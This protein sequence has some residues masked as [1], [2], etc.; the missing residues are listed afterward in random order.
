MADIE[1][2]DTI[3][4]PNKTK[5]A[6]WAITEGSQE[7][8]KTLDRILTDDFETHE[9]Q[10][11]LDLDLLL[12]H[13]VKFSNAHAVRRL[14]QFGADHTQKVSTTDLYCTTGFGGYKPAIIN[15]W[16]QDKI[17]IKYAQQHT[18]WTNDMGKQP[19]LKQIADAAKRKITLLLKGATVG[20][21]AKALEGRTKIRHLARRRPA[22]TINVA[23]QKKVY[24]NKFRVGRVTC[25]PDQKTR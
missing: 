12:V 19:N 24:N 1:N 16:N 8:N 7:S 21:I 2:T 9:N 23:S 4:A 25:L 14:L 17:G 13:A 22:T 3:E 15:Q 18:S 10:S 6:A 5:V 20:K 11:E